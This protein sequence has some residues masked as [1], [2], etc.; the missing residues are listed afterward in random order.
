MPAKVVHRH[1]QAAEQ[2]LDVLMSFETIDSVDGYLDDLYA[3]SVPD[4]RDRIG[5]LKEKKVNCP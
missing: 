4:T 5:R 1:D 2:R 3:F